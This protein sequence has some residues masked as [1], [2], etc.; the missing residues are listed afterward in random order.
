[1]PE[2]PDFDAP[3]RDRL[4][5]LIAWRR[6]VRR[7]RS[8]PVDEDLLDRL[9]DLACLAPSVGNSQPWRFVRVDSPERRALVRVYID[10]ED[11]IGVDDCAAVSHQVSGLLDV[12][13]PIGGE[14][15]LE[16][17]SP[18]LDR[19]LFEAAHYERF[20]GREARVTLAVPRDAL[21]RSTRSGS[22]ANS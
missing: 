17:S 9:L 20:R 22:R 11:G 16:M 7:F 2:T 1:M 4:A 12:E 6:D 21:V 18:G 19:P 8:E 15:D 10:A 13:D 5:D 14:Y 3:F